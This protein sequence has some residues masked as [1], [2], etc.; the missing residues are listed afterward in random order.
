MNRLLHAV[1][2][3][4]H[5]LAAQGPIKIF[6]HH[7]TLHGLEHLPFDEAV[8]RAE[9]LL[10]GRAYLA[11]AE[12]RRLYQAGR[13]D[14]EDL[15]AALAGR[16]VGEMVTLGNNCLSTKQIERLAMLHPWEP[17]APPELN[18]QLT[19][20]S[21]PELQLWEACLA[22]LQ[23]DIH[24]PH[25]AHSNDHGE[26]SDLALQAFLSSLREGTSTLAALLSVL[27]GVDL[28]E[29]IR[30]QM[31]GWCSA[32]LD[33]GM[34]AWSMPDRSQGFY[35]TWR[36]R[37]P[38]P[39]LPAIAAEAAIQA[40]ET[41][42]VAPEAWDA[43]VR[44]A[45]LELPGWA[46]MALWLAEHPEHPLQQTAPV[47]LVDLLAVRLQIEA[48]VVGQQARQHWGVEGRSQSLAEYFTRFPAELLLRQELYAGRLSENMAGEVR[49]LCTLGAA[50]ATWQEL[51]HQLPSLDVHWAG[52][53]AWP[54]FLLCR[55]LGL[56]GDDLSSA[57]VD[58]LSSILEEFPPCRH[59]AVWQVAYENHYRQ[60]LVDGLAA[61]RARGL[62]HPGR[63]PFAQM[64]LCIDEREESFRRHLEE[65]EP[66][67]ETLGVAGFFGVV[68]AYQGLSD[69]ETTNLCPVVARPVHR[70]VEQPRIQLTTWGRRVRHWLHA[71]HETFFDSPPRPAQSWLSAALSA[72]WLGLHMAGLLVAPL[73][74]HT[75]LQRLQE[76]TVPALP[77]LLPVDFQSDST[78]PLQSGFT[79]QEQADRVETTLRGIGLTQNMARLVVICAHGSDSLNNPHHSAHDCGACSGRP[80]GPNA[81]A[82]ASMANQPAVRALLAG[83]GLPIPQDTWFLGAEHNTCSEEVKIFDADLVPASHQ[84]DFERFRKVLGEA[85]MLSAQERCRRFSSAPVNPTPGA[86]LDHM[87]ARALDISQP[88]PEL[89]HASNASAFVGRRA[90]TRGLFLDR[91][92]FLISYD[93]TSDPEGTIL[94]RTLL[95]VG[96]VGAGINL[97]YYFSSVDNVRYGCD[98]KLPHNITGL[99]GVMEGVSSDLRTGLPL[100]MV[101]IHEP[102]R[103]QIFV[104]A[105]T[106]VL[107]RIYMR[108]PSL[109]QLI[110]HEWVHLIAIDPESGQCS[111]FTGGEFK[112]C[113][114]SG[115]PLE[116]VTTSWHAYAG[117]QG[118]VA[119]KLIE[120][121]RSFSDA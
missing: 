105:T 84:S 60:G 45:L 29:S 88:R 68:I 51:A 111:F 66:A 103:L 49:P 20:L 120:A 1:E 67:I 33:A 32:F 76:Q 21:E 3:A 6:I 113:E 41:L 100:Q 56:S 104:E 87:E 83:R 61:N 63:R 28:V 102:V 118:F 4:S 73:G 101:E 37:R 70:L 22:A 59:G 106:E 81:R 24:D 54:L 75:F 27:C 35:P 96:P 108:Q 86:A 99:I 15:D 65:I 47:S 80:G 79:L 2:H 112:P 34:A 90:L 16:P 9:R 13:I 44:S 17:I 72:P 53:R 64:V 121:G 82:F 94:E 71:L 116:T 97:E 7:N 62:C 91:R 114:P 57:P 36:S 18:W 107:T 89:G 110:G 117:K 38:A 48:E 42:G 26:R 78:G 31:I 92:A 25:A 115:R 39:G 55:H 95:A 77:T 46:G 40:L 10:G 58:L 23:L 74:W 93:P 98:T 52:Q 50:P 30:E 14:D 85:R 119:P 12:F 109:Q 43:Y 19:H 8:T 11:N 69:Y 5:L